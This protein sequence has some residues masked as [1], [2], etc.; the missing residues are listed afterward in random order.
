MS[1]EFILIGALLSGFF[2]LLITLIEIWVLNC[3]IRDNQGNDSVRI[4]NQK[5][6]EFRSFLFSKKAQSISNLLNV[7]WSVIILN[8]LAYLGYALFCLGVGYLFFTP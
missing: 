1:S 5:I 4:R 8:S 2:A 3:F 6:R 7:R